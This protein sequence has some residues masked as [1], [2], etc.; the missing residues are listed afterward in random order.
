VG[1]K[2]RRKPLKSIETA[3]TIA[4]A[5]AARVRQTEKPLGAP[6]RSVIT[7]LPQTAG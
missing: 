3:M 5:W 4:R 6:D 7:L 1:W 2:W